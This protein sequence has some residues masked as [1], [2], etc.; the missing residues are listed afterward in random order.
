LHVYCTNPFQILKKLNCD[1]Y[2]INL[3][4]DFGISSIFNIEDLVDYNGLYFNPS[5]FFINEL[6]L[7]PIFE[8]PLSSIPNILPNRV[9]Q[10]DN[11]LND[12]VIMTSRYL[13]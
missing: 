10:I 1:A 5:N 4:K 11:I 8:S 2:V 12:E 7:E 13:V 6:S 9:D 3:L